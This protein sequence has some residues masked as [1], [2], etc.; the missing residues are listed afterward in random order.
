MSGYKEHKGLSPSSATLFQSCAR[1]YYHRKVAKTPIDIDCDEDQEA[2]QVGKA[3]HRCLEDTKHE[4]TGFTFAKCVSVCEKYNLGA[5][6]HAPMIY[7]MLGKYKELHE[8]AETRAIACEI[9]VETNEFYGFIDVILEDKDGYFW[10]ADMK[11]AGNYNAQIVPSLANNP[12][13]NLYAY[14]HR[15]VLE[16]LGLDPKK[17]MGCRYRI[18]TK[19]KLVRK[20][21]ESIP[22]YIRRMSQGIRS[23]DFQLP[24]LLMG[25]EQIYKIHQEIFKFVSIESDPQKYLPNYG[26]CLSYFRPCEFWSR[27]HGAVFSAPKNVKFLEI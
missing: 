21:E 27:C 7:A 2:F 6:T 20:K 19:S 14:H 17:F 15:M 5:D 3:F 11:T 1:R 23:F 18:T 10:I 8:L 25:T 13:L 16:G 12:Q 24:S 22:D 26:N 9:E 4:L